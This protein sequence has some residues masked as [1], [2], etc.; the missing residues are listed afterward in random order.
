MK[1]A[2]EA[3]PAWHTGAA[4]AKQPC[5]PACKLERRGREGARHLHA[6]LQRE[7]VALRE[8]ELHFHIY[9]FQALGVVS[10]VFMGGALMCA[11]SMP[12][13]ERPT[14]AVIDGASLAAEAVFATAAICA[15]GFFALVAT[16]ALLLSVY[17]PRL[18]LRA[19]RVAPLGLARVLFVQ[20]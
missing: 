16:V 9:H 10:S 7:L 15:L 13:R 1:E 20:L 12:A 2:A 3:K 18:A 14:M 17:A 8:R 11:T 6:E 5:P 4:G 19:N